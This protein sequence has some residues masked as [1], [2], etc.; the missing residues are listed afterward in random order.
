MSINE[1]K[2]IIRILNNKRIINRFIEIIFENLLLG[3]KKI[4]FKTKTKIFSV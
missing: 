1:E 2:I 3:N 4:S